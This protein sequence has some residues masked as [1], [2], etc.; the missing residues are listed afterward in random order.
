MEQERKDLLQEMEDK[1]LGD[2]E[3]VI[4]LENFKKKIF[5]VA[6]EDQLSG[7]RT[8]TEEEQI[9]LA[10]NTMLIRNLIKEV[11]PEV[12]VLEMCQD[13][14]DHWFY[15]AIAHPNYDR[16]LMD[17]HRLLDKGSPEALL[18]YKGVDFS[19][20]SSHLEFLVGLD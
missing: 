7:S 14:Y 11:K 12:V 19:K 13:R 3:R 8:L 9:A 1:Y 18:E 16:T 6:V 4:K 10:K 17:V 20:S 5:A 2:A 15:D